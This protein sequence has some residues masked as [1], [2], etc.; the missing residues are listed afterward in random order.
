MDDFHCDGK[1]DDVCERKARRFAGLS[2]KVGYRLAPVTNRFWRH[3]CQGPDL[4]LCEMDDR[5]PLQT[6][7]P[8]R[9]TKYEYGRS[10]R[11]PQQVNLRK[12]LIPRCSLDTSQLS[13]G[14]EGKTNCG[15]Q[16]LLH[17]VEASPNRRYCCSGRGV[18][19]GTRAVLSPR[20]PMSGASRMQGCRWPPTHLPFVQV[21]SWR[22]AE[23]TRSAVG[24]T[25]Q[26]VPLTE[27]DSYKIV[28]SG[29]LKAA[30]NSRICLILLVGAGRFGLPA[31][32]AQGRRSNRL[33]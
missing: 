4:V 33:S 1:T 6:C 14:R 32:C 19:L 12:H 26:T 18:P 7:Y 23:I 8:R 16:L 28:Y 21:T 20:G 31:P 25:G 30:G 29:I 15:P 27:G 13:H 5:N 10:S 22:P 17:A 24:A 3:T 11:C 2:G 9:Q